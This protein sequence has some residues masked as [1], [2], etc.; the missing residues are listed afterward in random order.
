MGQV[1]TS[2]LIAVCGFVLS[3]AL[4]A[5]VEEALA[6][7]RPQAIRA[8]MRFLSD[9]LLEGR[10]TA[11]RGY[12]IAARYVA[13]RFEELGL[14]PTGTGG[15]YFQ[16]VPLMQMTTVEAECSL[17]LLRDGR[18]IELEYG[19]DFLVRSAVE[20]AS[21][22][23]PVVFAG[24]GVTAPELGYDDYAGLDVRGK[25]VAI[26]MGS[27]S[28]FPSD[29]R[30]Y[31]SDR[32]VQ[33][34]NAAARGAVGL[35]G[36]YT[37]ERERRSSW[38]TARRHS[39]WPSSSWVDKAG[40]PQ[41]STLLPAAALSLKGAKELFAGAP[42]T[43]EEIYA[44]AEAGRPP[45]FEL[46]VRASL[47]TAG[48]G[49]RVESPNVAAVLRGSDPKLR[50]EY[51][52]LSAHLDHVGME[53]SGEG[54]IIYNGAYDNASGIAVMLEVANAFT[55]LPA[56]RRSVLFLAVTGEEEGLNGSD[57]FAHQPTVPIDRIVANTNLDMFLML[58]PLRD[59]IAFGAEHSSL[60][61]V[62]REAA[63]RLG[64]EVSPDPFPEEVLFIRSDHYAFVKQGVPAI[65]LAVGLQSADPAVDG[66][67]LWGKWMKEVY[68]KPGDDM[69][70]AIDFGAGV[71]FAKL[72][73]LV[74]YQV[75]QE[76]KAPTWNPG[77]FFGSQ[78]GRPGVLRSGRP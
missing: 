57:Y 37:P 48:K 71:Q 31:Y 18:E 21:A 66:K 28:T 2:L 55:R 22:T 16:P 61:R 4:P 33:A 45:A 6:A 42:R 32:A 73:F 10:G 36:I 15:S 43:L 3:E 5:Q 46:P 30:A 25:V 34:R 77:D 53:P 8:H 44:A 40:K 41:F 67:A 19:P 24:F 52:V 72:N 74:S 27:P 47:R 63:G 65:F 11:T 14:E 64:I 12:D 60:D 70:Q 26:L 50:D 49:K 51:V 38:E 56:P 75:A 7:I 58:Y 23:A 13:T 20:E 29:Q 9:D 39:H 35:L 1:R 78:F 62:V 76:E 54:D 68:H 59:V 17:T 69:S